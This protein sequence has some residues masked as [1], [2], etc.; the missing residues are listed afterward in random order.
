[1]Q[2]Q[3]VVKSGAPLLPEF[4]SLKAPDPLRECIRH[5]RY[6]I[7]VVASYV[8]RVRAFMRI[9]RLRRPETAGRNKC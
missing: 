9:Q 8:Y 5:L 7:R 4:Q 6:S 2:H 1:M 3:Q